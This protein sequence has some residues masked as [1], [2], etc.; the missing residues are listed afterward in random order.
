MKRIRQQDFNMT[1]SWLIKTFLGLKK[2]LKR[3]TT[4][5]IEIKRLKNNQYEIN[6]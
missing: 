5:I 1:I 6:N 3:R 2:A 4:E